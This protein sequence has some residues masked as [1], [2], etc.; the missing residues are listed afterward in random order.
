VFE[1]TNGFQL[2]EVILLDAGKTEAYYRIRDIFFSKIT[3][4]LFVL[5]GFKAYAQHQDEPFREIC[6][7]ELMIYNFE[8]KSPDDQNTLFI[9]SLERETTI[10]LSTQTEFLYVSQLQENPDLLA[11]MNKT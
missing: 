6:G 10:S 9:T 4:Q 11:V 8:C 2:K 7:S 3:R 5:V 1:L